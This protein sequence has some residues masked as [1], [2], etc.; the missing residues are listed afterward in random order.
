MVRFLIY[1]YVIYM[2][3]IAEN[4]KEEI[5]LHWSKVSIIYQNEANVNL[6]V[7]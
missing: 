2:I 1:V 3:I 5:E 4:R 6:K 7:N